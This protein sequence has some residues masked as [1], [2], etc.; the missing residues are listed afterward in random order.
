MVFPTGRA[1]R[2]G[3]K[4]ILALLA[5]AVIPATHNSVLAKTTPSGTQTPESL[6]PV[7]AYY[8]PCPQILSMDNTVA[9]IVNRRGNLV[10]IVT[11]G[12]TPAGPCTGRCKRPVR[13][14]RGF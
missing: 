1:K 13:L 12:G 8:K 9:P 10:T 6:P 4:Q 2:G 14:D 11:Q 5:L 3:V 7:D